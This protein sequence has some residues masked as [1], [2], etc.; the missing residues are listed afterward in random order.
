MSAMDMAS[1]YPVHSVAE[2]RRWTNAGGGRFITWAATCGAT[3]RESGHELRT[4]LHARKAE[5][6]KVCWPDGHQTYHATPRE[7]SP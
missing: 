7:V 4:A 2:Y 1:G 6:C 3:G 5:L